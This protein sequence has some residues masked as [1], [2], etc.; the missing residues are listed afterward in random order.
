MAKYVPDEHSG[1]SVGVLAAVGVSAL[2]LAIGF[3][4]FVLL[5]RRA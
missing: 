2:A 1:V 4:A 5:T 3:A